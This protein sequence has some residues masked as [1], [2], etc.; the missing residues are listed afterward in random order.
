MECSCEWSSWG[1]LGEFAEGF[2]AELTSL[3][4]SAY[5]RGAHLRLMRDVSEWL[6]GRGLS[7]G[8]L[9]AEVIDEFMAIRRERYSTLRS[10]RAR[11]RH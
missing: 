11:Q 8:G 2:F 3:G 9:T 5:S 7:A 10:A 4:Y 6:G 1:P